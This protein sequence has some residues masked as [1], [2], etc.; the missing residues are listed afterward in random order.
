MSTLEQE[1]VV[2]WDVSEFGGSFKEDSLGLEDALD[3][4]ARA[5]VNR[6]RVRAQ[7]KAANAEA[8]LEAGRV[9]QQAIRADGSLRKAAARMSLD[10]KVAW[11]LLRAYRRA[12]MD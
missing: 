6:E 12:V 5:Q 1:P 8:D 2:E 9:V 11:K 3:A 10:H 4:C 7:G